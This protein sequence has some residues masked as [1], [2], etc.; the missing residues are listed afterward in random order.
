VV[1]GVRRTPNRSLTNPITGPVWRF[2]ISSLIFDSSI[3]VKSAG[4]KEGEGFLP[5]SFQS[6]SS[7][8]SNTSSKSSVMWTLRFPA[9]VKWEFREMRRRR[10]SRKRVVKFMMMQCRMNE[11][12]H[13]IMRLVAVFLCMKCLKLGI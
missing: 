5:H 8:S 6:S 11:S 12:L 10:E 4:A 9:R 3:L 7:S 2:I 13:A 1:T